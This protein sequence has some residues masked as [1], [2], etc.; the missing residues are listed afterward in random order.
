MFQKIR[1]LFNKKN[2][3]EIQSRYE[4]ITAQNNQLLSRLLA[5][6]EALV[7]KYNM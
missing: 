3:D 4:E 5:E 2:K 7:K 6:D 1:S